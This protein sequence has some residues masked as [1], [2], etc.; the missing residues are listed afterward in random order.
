M[1]TAPDDARA[2][3]A[4]LRT[5]RKL[6]AVWFG[7]APVGRLAYAATGFALMALKYAADAG[8]LHLVT[9][10]W[11]TPLDYVSPLMH[12][13]TTFLGEEHAWALWPML[14][15]TIP[16]VWIGASMTLRRGLDAGLSAWTG[17]IFFAPV[18]NYL[19]MLLLCTL[20][21]REARPAPPGRAPEPGRARA[22]ALAAA[23]AAAL[24]V[25]AMA[26]SVLAVDSYGAMLFVGTPF[27]MGFTAGYLLNRDADR[28]FVATQASAG[29]AVLAAGGAL[30]LFALEGVIC[31]AMAMPPAIVLAALGAVLGRMVARQ[32]R[33]R[34]AQAMAQ[35][36]AIPL[37][38]GAESAR[39]QPPLFEV[40]SSIEIDAPPELVWPHVVGFSELPPPSQLVFRLGIAYPVRARIEGRGVGAVRYC[41]F[42]TGPFVEPITAWDE[43]RRLSFDVARQPAPMRETSPD[44]HVHAPHLV[45]ALLSRRGEFRLTPLPGGR[46][47]LEGSTWY[48]LDM[49]P[50][51]YWGVYADALIGAIHDR[52]L[53]H[54]KHLAEASSG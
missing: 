54:V 19:W 4:P 30:V 26:L 43:P 9:G 11:W 42:S 3:G 34:P 27:A 49:A 31:L 7:S 52:V 16:F 6:L 8:F 46:T 35:I 10:R 24:G 45:D 39:P 40:A 36:L 44:R 48:Q 13:R 41:E 29:V 15:W 51:L 37:L 21:N 17:L 14:A 20:P 22:I 47:R 1:Q 53:A 25:A 2:P 33:L 5:P 50:A 28:G 32:H 23:P 12:A 18:L 38:I